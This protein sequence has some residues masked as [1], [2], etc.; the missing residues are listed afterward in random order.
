MAPTP[1]CIAERS[2]SLRGHAFH[3]RFKARVGSVDAVI[4]ELVLTRRW[5]ER[6]EAFEEV[7]ALEEDPF[8][9]VLLLLLY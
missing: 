9:P 6:S 7:G 4:A 8:C 3:D 5:D 1:R 2:L